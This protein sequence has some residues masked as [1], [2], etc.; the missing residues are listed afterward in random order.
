VLV[1]TARWIF[2]LQMILSFMIPTLSHSQD[3]TSGPGGLVLDWNRQI[4]ALAGARLA[5]EGA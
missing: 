4:V 3:R 1:T 2:D 5:V